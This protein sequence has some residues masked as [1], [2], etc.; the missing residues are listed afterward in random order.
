[1]LPLSLF[2][3]ALS[4]NQIQSQLLRSRVTVSAERFE[5]H[6]EDWEL[7]GDRIGLLL[8]IT[9]RAVTFL[10]RVAVVGN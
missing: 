10:A 5:S 8:G 6:R 3:V 7:D 1:M 4:D 2:G 9:L